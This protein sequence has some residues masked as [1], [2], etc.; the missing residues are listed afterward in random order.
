MARSP[1]TLNLWSAAHK[2]GDDYYR[3]VSDSLRNGDN[4]GQE[5]AGL[6]AA[7]LEALREL[8]GHLDTL[9]DQVEDLRGST[10]KFIDLVLGDLERFD[11][12]GRYELADGNLF[13]RGATNAMFRAANPG[14]P[15]CH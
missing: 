2:S 3:H 7:Y 13:T 12:T 11:K 9:D 4:L 10:R 6:A 8:E 5:S 15:Q 1:H 14:R